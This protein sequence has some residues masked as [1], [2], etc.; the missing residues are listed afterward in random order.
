MK[1]PN[2]SFMMNAAAVFAILLCGAGGHLVLA[3]EY[4]DVIDDAHVPQFFVV[5][6][7]KSGT[8]SLWNYLKDHPQFVKTKLKE[9]FL[10]CTYVHFPRLA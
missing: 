2:F 4:N 5:G 6:S 1:Y 3:L 8:S 10:F 7:Q 9:T